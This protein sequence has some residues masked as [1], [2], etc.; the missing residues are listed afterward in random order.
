MGIYLQLA[1]LLLRHDMIHKA[2]VSPNM[3][4]QV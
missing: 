3:V 1:T 2:S 4:V